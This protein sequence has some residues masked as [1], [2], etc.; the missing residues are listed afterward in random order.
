M[1]L[2]IK[3]PKTVEKVEKK[4]VK[5]TEPVKEESEDISL[6][7][8]CGPKDLARI[9]AAEYSV[10]AKDAEAAIRNTIDIICNALCTGHDVSFVGSFTLSLK[11]RPAKTAHNPRTGE[12]MELPACTVVRFKAGNTLKKAVNGEI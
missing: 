3:K 10:S 2:K 12:K 8:K 5:K 6:P 9:Y 4:P 7:D 11:E 1:G